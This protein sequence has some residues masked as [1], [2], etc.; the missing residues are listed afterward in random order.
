MSS[1][2]IFPIRERPSDAHE[3]H[4]RRN[5]A[6]AAA[7]VVVVLVLSASF[8]VLPGFGGRSSTV[9]DSNIDVLLTACSAYPVAVPIGGP[10]V[11]SGNF[12]VLG[13]NM[14]QIQVLVMS[15]TVYS[16]FKHSCGVVAGGSN[17]SYFYES[18][19]ENSANFSVS[20][21][22]GSNCYLVYNNPQLHNNVLL[23]RV[24]LQNG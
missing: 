6:V 17:S 10:S 11:L 4:L 21:P 13:G 19:Q 9:V 2:G 18:P 8:G 5:L 3:S 12:K 16:G 7:V 20:L 15:S 22:G 1:G 23:T 14:N 24:T